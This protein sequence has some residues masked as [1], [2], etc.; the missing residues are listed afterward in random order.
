VEAKVKSDQPRRILLAEDDRFLRKAAETTLKQQG[1]TVI[2]AADGEEALRVARSEPL[3]LILL[4][5]IM[6][7]LNGFQVLNALK[8]DAPTAHVPVIILSNLG[9]ERDVQQAMEAGATAYFIKA[10][11]SLHALVQRVEEA[12]AAGGA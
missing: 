1:Y 12:L 6:P 3:D 7:K 4:D 2:T 11:L 8:K 10:D 9:Q 5:L